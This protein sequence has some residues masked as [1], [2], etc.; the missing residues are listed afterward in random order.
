MKLEAFSNNSKEI[1][2]ENGN[3]SVTV[4]SWANCEGASIMV[5]GEG[6]GYP[7]RMA[8]AFRWEEIDLIIAA[9]AAA[10]AA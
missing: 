7:M 6:P 5:H 8:G 1:F 4:N 3:L 2:I 9:L 10:R